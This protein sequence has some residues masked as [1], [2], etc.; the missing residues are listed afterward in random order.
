M[1]RT[2]LFVVLL[3]AALLI[4]V[5]RSQEREDRALLP[6][7]QMQAIMNEA[8]G[9]RAMHHI[10]E[11]VAYPRVR[12]RAE[13]EGAFRESEVMM[14]YA[15]EYGYTNV[16]LETFP[17]PQPTWF[18]TQGELW[19]VEP[20]RRKL[21][22]LHD[23]AISVAP[24]S[25]SGDVTAEV[26]DVGIG[27]RAE[28][29]AN[30]D[31]K[32]KIVLGSAGAGTL[33]RLGVFERGAVG[34]I[35]YNS[36]RPDSYP[37]EIL[38]QSISRTGPQGRAP[39]FGWAV[40]PRVARGIAARLGRGEKV[41]LRSV[42]KSETAPGELE[43]VHAMIPGDGSTE[44][45]IVVS[46]HL[47][48]GY[49]KQGA[50]DDASGCAVTLEMGRTLI[51]LIK[52]GQL[53]RPRRN[54]HFLWVPE[55]SGTNAWLRK[56]TDV[57]KRLV[58][59]LN[60]DMEGLHLAR[61]GS[62]W[63]MHRTPDSFPSF[64]NDVGANLMEFVANLNRERV[65][66]RANGYSFTWPVV[67]PNGSQDDP[68]LIAVEK[69]YGAS[70][71]VV[72]LNQGIPAV[73]FVTWP[74][75]WYH[76]S[77]DT[78]DKL[79]STQFKRVAVV[80]AAVTI[81]LASSGD[82]MG[83]KISAENL[84]RGTERLGQAQRKALAYL[85]DAADPAA[86]TEAYKDSLATVRHQTEV[87]RGVIR[88]SAVLYA[89][90]ADAQKK[91]AAFEAMLDQRS[92]ALQSEVRAFYQL[93]AGQMN[94]ST[95]EP[96][97]SELEQQAAKLI[98]ERVGQTGGGPGGGGGAGGPGGQGTQMSPQ[99]RAALQAAQR[100]IPGHMTA[101][102]NVLF[103]QQA[104]RKRT[105]LEIRNFLTGEFEPLSLADLMDYF[106]AMEKVGQLKFT[107]KAPEPPPA[108]AKKAPKKRG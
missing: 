78:P 52:E 92:T 95:E 17:S 77:H 103:S 62:F 7:A 93:R 32:G 19:M 106:R 45:E 96:K 47:Y 66:Y 98:P 60:F 43:V 37:D 61:S 85:A 42:V 83:A 82:E 46:A 16:E 53:P 40:S 89:N 26:V 55:I 24:G 38:S 30:K 107:E 50:N 99:D 59:D 9:E 4:P 84:A 8:S 63:T 48:E 3:V 73:I 94:T 10:L 34:V 36:L 23:V 58:A 1:R 25:E 97:P 41:V 27:G 31:V 57:A 90:P 80:G 105:A 35:S 86:L 68:F 101:E 49:I 64:L 67:S 2:A 91:L 13:Y 72:Y 88:S 6:W 22:D 18:A 14:R 79:D 33:Q 108:P 69:H 74:D 76:S 102:L 87:E 70:D 81:A 15:K 28:D 29:Y 54:I 75:M 21:Y 104:A 5:L 44:Q 12:P 71:H 56:H 39:G 100:K 51:R 11:M 65:R 20:Q